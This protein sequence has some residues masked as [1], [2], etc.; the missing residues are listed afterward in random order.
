MQ[1]DPPRASTDPLRRGRLPPATAIGGPWRSL[2]LLVVVVAAIWLPRASALDRVV[3]PD[4]HIW[5][6]RSANFYYALAHGNFTDT[7]QFAHP[8][9]TVMWAGAATYLLRYPEYAGDAPGQVNQWFGSELAGILRSAGQTPLEMLVASRGVLLILHTLILALAFLQAAR[10]LGFAS[11]TVGFLLVAWNPFHISLSQVLHLDA[12]AGNLMFLSTLALLTYRYRGH[13]R[14][15]LLIAAVAAGLAWLTRSSALILLG[16][17]GLVMISDLVAAWREHRTTPR[18]VTRIVLPYGAWGGIGLVVFFALW[19]AMWVNPLGSLHQM[20][21]VTSEMATEGHELPLFFNGVIVQGDPGALFYPVSYLWRATPVTL[22]GLAVIVIALILPRTKLIPPANR[23]PLAMLVV[24][25]LLFTIAMGFGAK[26]FDRYLLPAYPPLDLVAGAGWVVAASWF[27]RPI[28]GF[29]HPPSW[30]HRVAAPVVLAVA[31]IGQALST[32]FAYPYYYASYNPLLGGSGAAEEVMMLGWGEGLDQIAAYLNRQPDAEESF[33][34]T[35]VWPTSLAYFFD[36]TTMLTHFDPGILSVRQ[37]L[38]SD[39][40]LRYIT[41]EQRDLVPPD[42]EAV[43]AAK[44]PLQTVEINGVPYAE[45]HDMRHMPL[46]A[47]LLENHPCVTNFGESVRFLGYL[48]P[49]EPGLPGEELT[50]TFY[51]ESLTPLPEGLRLRLRLLDGNGDL[52][53][54]D[55]LSVPNPALP[56][57]VWSAAFQLQLPNN[58]SP[59][60]NRFALTVNDLATGATLLAQNPLSGGSL[61]RSAPVSCD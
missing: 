32:G 43:F 48:W 57:A 46:P 38:I 33:V 20:F 34:L 58:A 9:V 18:Q 31:I 61:G 50:V 24:F 47:S 45:I 4:E 28:V 21:T 15:S 10:L 54:S 41:Q 2:A 22:V 26:K 40:Y 36:G 29:L 60:D 51:F 6:A 11:A 27:R 35:R 56:G 44:T 53:S 8:G 17:A 19:P 39:Y 7:Y 55:R 3:T 14:G 49:L 37:W 59:P 16:I 25:A 5:L 13:H 52:L 1:S 30:P 42:V 23:G 12:M